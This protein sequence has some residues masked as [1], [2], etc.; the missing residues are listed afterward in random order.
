MQLA[1]F[2]FSNPIP[3]PTMLTDDFGD[4][5]VVIPNEGC[6]IHWNNAVEHRVVDPDA[7]GRL[8][9]LKG[10]DFE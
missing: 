5:M 1:H 8:L 10:R 6:A 2:F 9:D 3:L 4:E 7:W